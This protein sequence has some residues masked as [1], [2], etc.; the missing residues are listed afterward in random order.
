MGTCQTWASRWFHSHTYESAQQITRDKVGPPKLIVIS[1][2]AGRDAHWR[3][4]PILFLANRD[5]KKYHTS[6]VSIS[7]L[8]QHD[9]LD[10]AIVYCPR[11]LAHLAAPMVNDRNRFV[12]Y[13]RRPATV[14]P[15]ARKAG[16]I[17]EFGQ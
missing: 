6:L 9:A 17:R 3:V 13:D 2:E 15:A 4:Q 16:P 14:R 8:P 10:Q 12:L 5:L 1:D 11:R 7:E